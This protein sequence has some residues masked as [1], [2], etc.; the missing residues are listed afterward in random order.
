MSLRA[1]QQTLEDFG[2]IGTIDS[3]KESVG[4]PQRNIAAVMAERMETYIDVETYL[5]A[6]QDRYD[7][8][9]GG[10]IAQRPTV[11]KSLGQV[12]TLGILCGVVTTTEKTR[13]RDKLA[14]AGLD[15]FFVDI[16]GGLCVE[17]RKPHPAP[18]LIAAARLGV[19]PKT[20]VA[21]VDSNTGVRSA[22]GAGMRVVQVPDLVPATEG[23]A[24]IQTET[25]WQGLQ[26]IGLAPA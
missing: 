13:A 3:L 26:A 25:I 11:S 4:M 19:D 24:Y 20:C 5:T 6:W 15:I 14:N 1:C 21:F 22:E 10:G 7:A 23:L 17:D 12:R 2:I 18:Y 9:L 16:T 8:L